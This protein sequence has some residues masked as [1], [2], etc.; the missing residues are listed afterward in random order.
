MLV[1]IGTLV[2]VAKAKCVHQ[3][4][5]DGALAACAKAILAHDQLLL[6]CTKQADCDSLLSNWIKLKLAW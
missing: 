6:A 1:P 5:D 4:V 2:L 3:F